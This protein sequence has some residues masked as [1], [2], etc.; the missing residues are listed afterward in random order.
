MEV[1]SDRHKVEVSETNYEISLSL[2]ELYEAVME[3]ATKRFHVLKRVDVKAYPAFRYDCSNE[4]AGDV[5]NGVTV[6]AVETGLRTV[7]ERMSLP[8]VVI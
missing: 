3:Y 1:H 7:S 4:D 8:K 2:E 5:V 6:H